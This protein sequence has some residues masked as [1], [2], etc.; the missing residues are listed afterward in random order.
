MLNKNQRD[1]VFCENA[2]PLLVEAGPGS[3]KTFVIVERIKF[4]LEKADPESFLVITFSRKAAKQLKDKLYDELPREIVD[5]MQIS[6]IHS[7]CLEFL[8]DN[9]VTVT[10][11]DDDNSEKKELFLKK[12]R[13]TLGFVDEF[14]I[15]NFSP[16]MSKFNEY[17]IYNV[18]TPKLVD[19]LRENKT[20]SYEYVE[21]VH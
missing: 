2:N 10:L 19:Y 21:L 4:L 18:D 14:T 20:Y 11:I 1:V 12:H 8:K 3:G 7:F 15:R 6:T 17:T 5:K 13:K 9:G 16:V